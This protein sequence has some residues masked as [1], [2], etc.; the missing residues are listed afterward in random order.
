MNE[1]VNSV[2]FINIFST[3]A[4]GQNGSVVPILPSHTTSRLYV[5]ILC[6]IMSSLTGKGANAMNRCNSK[7]LTPVNKLL[8]CRWLSVLTSLI[9][10]SAI[11]L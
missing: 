10:S 11:A 8:D 5:R 3:L 6:K 9:S 1:K 7:R 4:T 2:L